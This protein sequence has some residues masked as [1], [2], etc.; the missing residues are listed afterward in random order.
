MRTITRCT[1][2]AAGVVSALG[3]GIDE[4]WP[5]LVAADQGALTS[6]DDLVPGRRLIVGE[7][8]EPLPCIPEQLSRYACRNNQLAL[9]AIR[10][11]EPEVRATLEAVGPK[12][13]AVVMGT[14][15]SGMEAAEQAIACR[16]RTGALSVGFDFVQLEHGGLA[17]FVAVC[18]GARG[19]AYTLS[20]ACSS[21][22]KAVASA[23]AL[24]ALGLCDAA[25]AG[26]ADSL[27]K[28]TANGFHALQ[29]IAD[30]PSNPFSLNRQGLTL[31]EGA[32]VFLLT[33][34]ADGIQ[35]VGAGE[36]VDA[37]HMSAPEPEGAGAEAAMRAALDD[38]GVSAE[39][40]N[41]LNLHGTGTPL[42]DSMESRAV[43]RVFGSRLPCSSTKPLTGHA[44]GASGAVELAFCWM[45]LARWR[46]GVLALL[47]H[48]WDG[49]ADPAL[50][51]LRFVGTGEHLAATTGVLVMSNSFG[52]GGNNT[53]LL[54]GVES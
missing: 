18:T 38:A 20:T 21:G 33:R 24:L 1:L 39:A 47:P 23:R 31:G 44:L 5:R 49:V 53:A 3:H 11:I 42:N 14:S 43:H 29:A 32:A 16:A 36:A 50:P 37:F 7:V 28:L 6:R 2:R 45:M 34:D 30:G 51:P 52:F 12:R 54:L 19:P 10:Q 17:A 41:Y 48:Q 4:T 8:R 27:C 40:V 22:A 26:G 13:V 46:D 9:S 25:V 35:V 15:T